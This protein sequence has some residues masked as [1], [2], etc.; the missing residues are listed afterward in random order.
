MGGCYFWIPGT[1]GALLGGQEAVD[2]KKA[3]KT[4]HHGNAS[5]HLALD[6]I[7]SGVRL[8]QYQHW[9]LYDYSYEY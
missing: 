5:V 6:Q 4:V 2:E 3:K 9:H 7:A 8:Y 1:V